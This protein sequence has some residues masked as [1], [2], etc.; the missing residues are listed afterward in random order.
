MWPFKR[1]YLDKYADFKFLRSVVPLQ[2]Q[3]E[4]TPDRLWLERHPGVLLFV[5]DETMRSRSL[6]HLIEESVYLGVAFTSP[7]WTLWKKKLGEETFPIAL[8]G[9]SVG[10]TDRKGIRQEGRIK[11]EVHLVQPHVLWNTLDR[12]MLN[13]IEFRRERVKVLMPYHIQTK[14]V[15]IDHN[16]F[17]KE[18]RVH[19]YV[20][21]PEYWNNQ[22]D[23]GFSFTHVRR[24]QPKVNW[25]DGNDMGRYFF[26]SRLE[27]ETN[28]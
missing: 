20:G 27:Y 18:L 1:K 7:D 16:E 4:Y 15:T 6:Y 24:F 3:F 11:G 5:Y 14:G 17:I 10:K 22:L 8:N 25:V 26:Y 2:N 28:F 23:D 21:V 12:R 19:M 13:G 9:Q